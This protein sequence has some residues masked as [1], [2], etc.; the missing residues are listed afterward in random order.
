MNDRLHY[1]SD[2][3]LSWPRLPALVGGSILMACAVGWLLKVAFFHGW[4]W[5]IMVPWLAAGLLAWV[6]HLLV[7]WTQVLDKTGENLGNRS[8]IQVLMFSD[9]APA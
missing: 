7:G 9:A 5:V 2:A 6:M 8:P 3:G 4:Y 1:K